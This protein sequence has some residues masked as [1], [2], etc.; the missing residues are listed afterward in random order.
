MDPL[1]EE[2]ATVM[3]PTLFGRIQTRLFMVFTF[4]LVWSI[5]ILPILPKPEGAS[6][7]DVAG[8]VFLALIGVALIG[9][10]WEFLYHGLQQV[11][12]EKDWPSLFGLLTGINEGLFLYLVLD[13]PLSTFLVHFT[14]TWIVIWLA[15][16]GPMRVLFLRWRFRGGRLV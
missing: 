11:R 6:L 1:D 12:W 2:Q 5:I 3:T 10:V 7:G 4:G 14:T 16:H 13:M 8:D 9:I 15:L